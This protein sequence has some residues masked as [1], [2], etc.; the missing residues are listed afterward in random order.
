MRL[1]P[2]R[3]HEADMSFDRFQRVAGAAGPDVG[4]IV[5]RQIVEQHGG[6]ITRPIEGGRMS[7]VTARLPIRPLTDA[8]PPGWRENVA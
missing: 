8:D 2:H 6:Q 3:P 7:V 4:V 5:A 1:R